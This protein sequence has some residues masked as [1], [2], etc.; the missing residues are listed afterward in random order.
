MIALRKLA[1]ALI[2]VVILATLLAAFGQTWQPVSA[3]EEVPTPG[4]PVRRAMI[5]VA[6]TGY[7]W[8]LIRWKNNRI[9]CRVVVEHD[10]RPYAGEIGEACKEDVYE[11][12]LATPPCKL[13]AQGGDVTQCAGFYLHMASGGR[14]E[15]KVEV[16][17]PMPEVWLSVDGCDLKPPENRCE[18]LPSLILTGVEPLPNEVIIQLQGRINGQPFSCPGFQCAIPLQPTGT[19]GIFIEFWADSSYGDSSKTYSAQVRALPWGDFMAP[20]GGTSD[21]ASY[22]IDVI[23]SQFREGSLTSCTDIWQVF[24]EVGGAPPWLSTPDD[25]QKLESAEG[26]YYLAGMLIQYGAVDAQHCPDGG[27]TGAGVANNCGVEAARPELVA[28]QNQFNQDIVDVARDTGI[29]A[30]LMKNIFSRESQFWPGLYQTYLETGLGQMTENG[31]DTLLLW[32]PDFFAEFCP[33]VLDRYICDQRTYGGMTD[34]EVYEFYEEYLPILRGALV[35]RLN[36]SCKDCPVGIDLTQA[37]FSIRVF[38]ETLVANCHQVSQMIYNTTEKMP[39]QVSSFVDLWK[40]TLVN[41]N[42]GPGCL[43]SA[44][45]AAWDST[46]RLNWRLVS[47]ELDE[48]CAQSIA[49]VENISSVPVLRPTATPLVVLRLPTQSSPPPVIP[50]PTR[51]PIGPTATPQPTPTFPPPGG[52]YTPTPTATPDN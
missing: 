49:Y 37:R 50:E 24:P 44:I 25:A 11:E 16:E 18:G 4:A 6:Y 46:G 47:R 9:A 2:M 48:T 32:N 22:Y 13:A 29:P 52:T 36:S 1:G 12:W 38:A 34:P 40:F 5:N 10:G 3:Q 17:L 51:A 31:A 21:H 7:E 28:W 43:G 33:L 35:A 42:A 26:F 23:S 27:L 39:G 19:Q 30:Q 41:Y 45:E 8:W 15:K 14:G 20:E